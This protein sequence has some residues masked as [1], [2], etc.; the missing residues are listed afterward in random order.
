MMIMR[1]NSLIF[2]LILIVSLVVIS[3]C[4]EELKINNEEKNRIGIHFVVGPYT[5]NVTTN[6]T[7]IVWRTNISTINNSVEYGMNNFNEYIEYGQ[8]NCT[9][10]EIT[11]HPSFSLGYYKV[12]SDDLIS[13][14][15]K[16]NLADNC[17]NISDYKFVVIGD[18]RGTWDNW[19]NATE[20]A[21]AINSESPDFV[22]HCGDM[23][24]EG[25]NQSQWDS[26]L[27][28]MKPLMQNTTLFTVYGNHEYN[29]S[30][31]YRIFALPNNEMW[32]SFDYGPC[33]FT[34]LN[35]YEPWSG[36]SLQYI[37]LESDLSSSDMPFKIVCF[38]EPIYCSGGHSHRSDIR[39]VWEPLFNKYNVNLV[40]Q[41]HCHYYQRI[42]PINE[43]LY[44]VTGGAGAPLSKP[45]DAWFVNISKKTFHYCVIDVSCDLLELKITAKDLNG[46]I[47]D[48]Y[49]IKSSV[50]L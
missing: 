13:K 46:D 37:W 5:Q 40:F 47:F 42:N 31:Y 14:E 10:H 6:S 16:F 18:S 21:K 34:I 26:W 2:V 49:I 23:V 17:N 20:I 33:H 12:I 45:E 19:R 22:I 50:F 7:T 28:L 9:H 48:E 27:R 35:D 4:I 3:G 41:A 43:T 32:Y 25:R 44:I 24:D 36:D 8:S 29:G 39:A 30:I 38:H 15:F 1:N 11:I